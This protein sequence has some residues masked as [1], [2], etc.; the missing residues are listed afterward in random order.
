MKTSLA[1]LP[2]RN[3][4]ELASIVDKIKTVAMPE[5]VILFG[6]Y[7]TGKNVNDKYVK[8][9]TTFNYVSDYDIL[10]LYKQTDLEYFE[11]EDRILNTY[12]FEA[13]LN[14][15]IQQI[16]AVNNRL[17]VGDYFLD[18]ILVKGIIL[19]DSG[20]THFVEPKQLSADEKI[21]K[22]KAYFEFYLDNGNQFLELAIDGFK[23]VKASNKRA[24]LI[25]YLLH[26]ATE[27]YYSMILL[28]YSG[29]KP[30][31]HNLDKFRKLVKQL[32]TEITE[33]FPIVEKDKHELFLFDLLKRAYIGGKY[34]RDFE[35]TY[36]DVEDL[37]VRVSR[38]REV[39]EQLCKERIA[40]L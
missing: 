8:D 15:I 18:E 11:I 10:V 33:V 34:K 20:T 9:A 36:Q 3:Q 12:E 32:S 24:N 17:S 6:S 37:I 7:A 4:Q 38:L 14:L 22:V 29:Y 16:D 39:A 27:S 26:Q 31:S 28:V 23:R 5:K 21:E 19:Y 2:I 25:A 30:K 13:P 40:A 35:V 1:H